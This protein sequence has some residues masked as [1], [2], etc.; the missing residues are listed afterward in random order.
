MNF[1]FT[2]TPKGRAKPSAHLRGV[3][4][5][6]AGKA[7]QEKLFASY[8]V[9]EPTGKGTGNSGESSVRRVAEENIVSSSLGVFAVLLRKRAKHSQK[10]KSVMN[11]HNE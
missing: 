1:K 2:L 3:L 4:H 11:K 9:P 10:E 7:I 5:L 6:P 8:I